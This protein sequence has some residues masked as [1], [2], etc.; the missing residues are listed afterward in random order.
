MTSEAV[1]IVRRL[2]LAAAFLMLTATAAPAQ[3]NFQHHPS[4]DPY[5]G[6]FA[7]RLPDQKVTPTAAQTATS[8]AKPVVVSGTLIVPADPRI[9]PKIRVGPPEDGVTHTMRTMPPPRCEPQ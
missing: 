2:A 3:L 9:D 5:R 8:A 1:M 6:L 4:K 7:A